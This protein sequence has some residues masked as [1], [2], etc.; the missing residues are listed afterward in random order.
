MFHFLSIKSFVNILL[1][2]AVK[3]YFLLYL[4]QFYFFLIL[5]KNVNKKK[6]KEKP[7]STRSVK[8]IIRRRGKEGEEPR[9]PMKPKL[10]LSVLVLVLV[11]VCCYIVESNC[12][13]RCDLALASYYVWPGSNLAFIAQV[14]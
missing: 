3:F 12:S 10:W 5:E 14:F 2:Y 11:S 1:V 8:P 6:K 9:N 13:P 4:I 7:H